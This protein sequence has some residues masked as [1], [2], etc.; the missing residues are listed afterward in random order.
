MVRTTALVFCGIAM[1]CLASLHAADDAVQASVQQRFSALDGT[2]EVPDFQRHMVPLLGK[3]GCNGRACHGS[4]QGRG[5]F[6]LQYLWGVHYKENKR[7][8]CHCGTLL[9]LG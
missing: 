9:V 5:G 3:L 1:L 6:R 4:F 8:S 2:D 7:H